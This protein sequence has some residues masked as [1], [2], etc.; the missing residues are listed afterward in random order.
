MTTGES[1]NGIMHDTM[2]KTACVEV[3]RW[4]LLTSCSDATCDTYVDQGDP[5][6][7]SLESDVDYIN[8]CGVF[9]IITVIY[10]CTFVVLCAFLLL[11]L[12]IG[13]MSRS[14]KGSKPLRS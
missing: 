14:V 7:D 8:R 11:N 13:I 9:P 3:L 4:E 12:V 2:I 5:I 10:F 1:W 6:L